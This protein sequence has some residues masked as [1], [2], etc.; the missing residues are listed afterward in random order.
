M[1]QQ[2][3]PEYRSVFRYQTWFRPYVAIEGLAPFPVAKALPIPLGQPGT[4][5][6]RLFLGRGPVS[7][8]L[9]SDCSV[10]FEQGQEEYPVFTTPSI[11]PKGASLMLK[12]G[13][14]QLNVDSDSA[15]FL[16]DVLL[17]EA[18]PANWLPYYG[19]EQPTVDE[20]GTT[21]FGPLWKAVERRLSLARQYAEI[22]IGAYALY[23]YPLVWQRLACARYVT[24][25]TAEPQSCQ[26]QT[27]VDFD[28]YVPFT[29]KVG[30]RCVNGRF[31]DGLSAKANMLFNT[32]LHMPFFILQQTLWQKDVNLRFLQEFWIIESLAQKRWQAPE[33]DLEL[34][35][36]IR[37]VDA[38]LCASFPNKS[39]Y[40]RRRIGRLIDKPSLQ[41]KM[42]VYLTALGVEFDDSLLARAR[43]LRNELA[44]GVNVSRDE[45]RDVETLFRVLP[46]DAMRK[47]LEHA[48]IFLDEK[49]K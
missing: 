37:D 31:S 8:E 16:V 18:A 46:W 5:V 4:R 3:I 7:I 48:G 21:V 41:D 10:F 24:C 25:V 20:K 40:L 42:R 49:S 2:E 38:L 45:V 1:T 33:P 28:N 12:T 14:S 44:H 6:L 36:L 30:A 43:R 11:G 13:A 22:I 26:L 17:F 27:P 47:E 9:P 32:D 29:L 23:Q 34:E 19:T 15:L 35:T 39:D